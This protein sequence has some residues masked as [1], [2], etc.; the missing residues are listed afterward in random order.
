MFYYNKVEFTP[1]RLC[2]LIDIKLTVWRMH[3]NIT[4]MKGKILG[5]TS[6]F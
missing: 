5:F 1:D 3:A 2:C 4:E 6:A